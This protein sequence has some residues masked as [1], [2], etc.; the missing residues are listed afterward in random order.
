MQHIFLTTQKQEE[1]TRLKHFTESIYYE[2]EQT[3]KFCRT[4]G[5]QVFGR[6]NFPISIE[7]YCALDTILCNEGIC[8]RDLARLIL[9]DRAN[10]GRLLNSLDK[11]KL[12]KRSVDIKNN[13]LVRKLNITDTGKK[14]LQDITGQIYPFY[15]KCMDKVNIE[16]IENLRELLGKIRNEFA[17]VVELQI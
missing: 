5:S 3:A 11:K 16:A 7:E 10:T 12:I 13:R 14:L 6:F 8:Q 1:M 4:L 2:I 17:Q 9:K 15:E